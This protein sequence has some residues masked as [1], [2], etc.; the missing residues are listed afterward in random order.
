MPEGHTIHRLARA[1]NR[2]FGGRPLS[3]SSPQGRFA[4]G[5]GRIDGRVL[6]KVE[7]YGKHLLYRFE[8]LAEQLHVHLGLYGTFI[9]G[10]L[11]PPDPRG[12]LRLRLQGPERYAD[13]R[14]PTACDLMPPG[15]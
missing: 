12:A 14:G 5:A 15:E 11:P 6:R 9:S 3:A 7:P 4:G 13:L 10:E 1:H 8:G 2:A